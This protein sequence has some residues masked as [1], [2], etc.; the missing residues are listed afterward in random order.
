M[1]NPKRLGLAGGIL[2]GVSIFLM[3]LIGIH[4]DYGQSFF[5]LLKDIYPGYSVSYIG[6]LIGLVYG[7]VDW[8]IGLY[9]LAW[10]YNKLN[11]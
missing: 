5:T 1:L 11:V 7:F 8:F 9:I 6:G 2:W 4:F 10:L 3:T